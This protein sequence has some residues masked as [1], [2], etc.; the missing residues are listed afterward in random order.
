[1]GFGIVEERGGE[2]GGGEGVDRGVDVVSAG[3]AFPSR[4]HD[5]GAV[6]DETGW[7]VGGARAEGSREG[8]H[9]ARVA[10][11]RAVGLEGRPRA[12]RRDERARLARLGEGATHDVHVRAA[13][14]EERHELAT[15]AG[16]RARD[17]RG[18]ARAVVAVA[19]ARG[20]EGRG[21]RTRASAVGISRAR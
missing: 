9:V 21:V 16:A 7:G 14:G 4:A 8:V 18:D 3:R 19:W 1:M 6:R 11:I 17:D 2:R 10:E 15:D 13:R 20:G 5:A 12:R